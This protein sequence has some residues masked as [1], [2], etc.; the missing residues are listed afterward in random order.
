M[1][2]EPPASAAAPDDHSHLQVIGH[3]LIRDKTS[4]QVLVNQRD[5]TKPDLSPEHHEPSR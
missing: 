4:G 2:T 5:I 3:V 1:P